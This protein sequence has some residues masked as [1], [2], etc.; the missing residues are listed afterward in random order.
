M[1]VVRGHLTLE[2]RDA[3]GNLLET[4]EGANLITNVGKAQLAKLI[5]Q[6]VATFP[7]YIALGIINTAANV[8]DTALASEIVNGGGERA[9]ADTIVSETVSVTDDTITFTKVFTFTNSF[10]IVEAGLLDD[11]TAGNLFAR[12]VF[13]AVN[14]VNGNVVTAIWKLTFA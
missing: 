10:A 12:R 8:L 6:L 9:A 13:A 7:S 1:S 2:L 3:S 11:P 4:R 5:G 14:V